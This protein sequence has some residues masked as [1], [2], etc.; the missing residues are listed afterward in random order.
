MES[1]SEIVTE[2]QNDIE[3]QENTENDSKIEVQPAPE[4][5]EVESDTSTVQMY[6]YTDLNKTM[7]AKSSVNVRSLPLKDGTKIGSLSQN[8]AVNVTGQCNETS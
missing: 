1:V 7:Y 6:T 2:I 8:Q 3:I 5:G 4:I